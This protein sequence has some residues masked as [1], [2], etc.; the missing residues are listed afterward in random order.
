MTC[1]RYNRILLALSVW[2]S[3]ADEVRSGQLTK[4]GPEHSLRDR[5]AYLPEIAGSMSI[6]CP[7]LV[8]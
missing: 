3:V 1:V 5:Q 8:G 6:V 2:Q 7:R 4:N